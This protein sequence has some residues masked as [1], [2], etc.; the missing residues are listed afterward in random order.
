MWTSDEPEGA[1]PE[2]PA[3]QMADRHDW[4]HYF[5]IISFPG[6]KNDKSE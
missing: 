1:G 6:G 3:N 4:K 2:S 5:A